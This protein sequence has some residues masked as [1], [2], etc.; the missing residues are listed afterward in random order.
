MIN[1]P[2]GYDK[3]QAYTDQ[4][5]L[6]PGG[7]VLKILDTKVATYTWG[8]VLIVR[9]DIAEGDQAGFYQKNFDTQTQEDKKWKGTFRVNLPKDDGTEQDN[10]TL[11]SL[12]TNMLAI[13]D[14]NDGYTWDWDE[15]RL[16]D[17]FVGGLFGNIEYSF[18]GRKGFYTGCRK[19]V[20]AE[21]IRKGDFK[22]PED[23]L[24]KKD[25]DS[26]IPDGFEAVTDESI[27]F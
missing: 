25:N 5:K 10:W 17:K 6:P 1:K 20:S 11:R 19:F 24:L 3:A 9:F 8:D 13:E 18:N 27:P 16:K 7:Y 26:S 22:I 12:K 14:S 23:K 15:T 4:E 21:K 2:K